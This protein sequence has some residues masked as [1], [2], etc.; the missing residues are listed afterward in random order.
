MS[1]SVHSTHASLLSNPWTWLQQALG[2]LFR[3]AAPASVVRKMEKGESFRVVDPQ[4]HELACLQGTLWVTHDQDP[5]DRILERGE[6]YAPGSAVCM[7]VHAISDARV[8]V[9]ARRR[10]R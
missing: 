2:P 8:A 5:E 10:P 9:T 1:V 6:R 7:L 3:T 4:L